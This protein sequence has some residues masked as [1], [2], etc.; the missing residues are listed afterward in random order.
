MLESL[1]LPFD[2]VWN[3]TF[4]D[5]WPLNRMSGDEVTVDAFACWPKAYMLGPLVSPF[6]VVWNLTFIFDLL[7][8]NDPGHFFKTIT[9]V[10][11]LRLTICMSHMTTLPKAWE[12]YSIFSESNFLT[13]VTKWPHIDI[14]PSNIGIGSQA[15]AHIWVLWSCYVI[16]K[17]YSNFNINDL[18]PSD[19]KWPHI[20]IWPHNIGRGSQADAHVWLLLSWYTT[21]MCYSIFSENDLLTPVTPNDPRLTFHSIA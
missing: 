16:W 11:K 15:N 10:E 14:W 7:T 2:V 8:P 4:F 3:L 9:F 6:D 12:S 21:W 20:D 5:L 18:S 19:P 1:V 13:P 17:S